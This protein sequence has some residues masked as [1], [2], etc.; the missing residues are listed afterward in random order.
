MVNKKM[1]SIE[2][3]ISILNKLKENFFYLTKQHFRKTGLTYFAAFLNTEIE[4]ILMECCRG[5]FI[6]FHDLMVELENE[7]IFS[8]YRKMEPENEE[9]F[10]E[11]K[12]LLQKLISN[13]EGIDSP[14][15]ILALLIDF[16]Y[17]V[18]SYVSN[19]NR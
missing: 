8:D 2:E 7:K 6:V 4:Y 10:S 18:F 9:F 5:D 15:T 19:A 17:S 3:Q 11:L 1:P 12:K 16:Y 14:R 13:S